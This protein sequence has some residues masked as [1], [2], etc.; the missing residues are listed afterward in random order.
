VLGVVAL[1][2]PGC[3]PIGLAAIVFGVHARSSIEQSAHELGGG[4]LA[5]AGIVLGAIAS[6]LWLAVCAARVL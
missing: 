6:A 2:T 4:G 3:V 5:T 1:L